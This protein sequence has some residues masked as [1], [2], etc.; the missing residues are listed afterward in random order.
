MALVGSVFEPRLGARYLAL[1]RETA[2]SWPTREGWARL[3][4][5][6]DGYVWFFSE[7]PRTDGEKAPIREFLRYVSVGFTEQELVVRPKD[8]DVD[9]RFR[10]ARFQNVERIAAARR[11]GRGPRARGPGGAPAASI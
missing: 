4:G 7:D 8:D 2:M 11:P 1:L 10:E 9:V 5:Y 6:F 3:G